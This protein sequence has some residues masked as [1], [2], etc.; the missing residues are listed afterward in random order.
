MQDEL[1]SKPEEMNQRMSSKVQEESEY[2]EL[3]G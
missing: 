2:E 1:G 3:D